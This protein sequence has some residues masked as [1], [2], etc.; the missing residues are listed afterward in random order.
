[1]EEQSKSQLAARR[2]G[3][4]PKAPA[5]RALRQTP[6]TKVL[7]GGLYFTN[8]NQTLVYGGSDDPELSLV[9]LETAERTV[10]VTRSAGIVCSAL[11]RDGRY[12]CIAAK[13]G[14]VMY[15]F[16][17]RTASEPPSCSPLWEV[18]PG[19]PFCDVAFSRDGATVAS[20]RGES[21]VVEIRD[22]QSNSSLH[23]IEDF[24]AC[25][26]GD[27]THGLSFSP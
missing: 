25:L 23:T 24:P 13:D 26:I 18:F 6:P 2:G 14:L 7:R 9:D 21:G 16:T 8:D 27:L 15:R 3:V 20:A 17:P 5:N 19:T 1:M 10:G 4:P 12:L 11:S 22:V